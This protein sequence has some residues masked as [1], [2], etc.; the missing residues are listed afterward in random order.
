MGEADKQAKSKGMDQISC[1][2]A[3]KGIRVN[4]IWR[5]ESPD[6]G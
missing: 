3:G 1:A 5:E 6:S 2:N 4:W